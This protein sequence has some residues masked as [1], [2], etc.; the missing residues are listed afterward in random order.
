MKYYFIKVKKTFDPNEILFDQNEID[1]NEIGIYLNE[2][3]FHALLI[4]LVD[5]LIYDYV[6][7]NS[8]IL[9]STNE[10]S[11]QSGSIVTLHVPYII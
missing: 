5:N 10:V 8:D 4:I 7:D 1:S 6:K 3:E 2:T 9:F 11:F